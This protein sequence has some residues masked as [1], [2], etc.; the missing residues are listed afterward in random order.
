MKKP[1]LIVVIVIA[2]MFALTAL[3][4]TQTTVF[5]ETGPTSTSVGW[6]YWT[7]ANFSGTAMADVERSKSDGTGREALVPESPLY[8]YP[9]Y[10]ALDL[11]NQ[12][13]YWSNY[14]SYEIRRANLDGTSVE[15]IITDWCPLGVAV[16]GSGGY[17][18]WGSACVGKI[19]RANLDGSGITDIVTGLYDP[20]TYVASPH[21]IALDVSGGKIYWANTAYGKIQRANL[22]GSSVE[23]IVTQLWYPQGVTLDLTNNKV[24]WT[25]WGIRR[26]N[27]DGSDA[28]LVLSAD[29]MGIAID[30]GGGKMYW[31]NAYGGTIQRAN[32][33]GTSVEDIVTTGLDYP[34]GMALLPSLTVAIDIIPY[35]VNPTSKGKI[36]V[37]ILSTPDFDAPSQVDKNS[38]TFGLTGNEQSLAFCNSRLK[39]DNQNG[40]RNAL[41]CY[42][43][44][45]TAG[46]QFQC[47]NTVGILK[48]KTVDNVPIQGSDSVRIKPCK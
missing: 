18:Y 14:G 25:G 28:E 16:D 3:S 33:N 35:S 34:W 37:A 43:Y 6:I 31:A 11:V 39:D 32:L 2:L 42:F 47:G 26:A 41:I 29:A 44:T 22:D 5:A 12:K 38:L 13:M 9:G 19:R 36:E 10:L 24:Y 40:L 48:G 8:T 21:G 15:T 7:N 27:L 23:D 46:F 45:Q 30:A 17:I 4:L 1:P 20:D